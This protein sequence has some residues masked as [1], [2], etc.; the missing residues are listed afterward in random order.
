MGAYN[1]FL[2]LRRILFL[3]LSLLVLS[4]CSMEEH[5]DLLNNGY[6]KIDTQAYL[7]ERP[8]GSG[9]SYF[10]VNPLGKQQLLIYLKSEL[11]KGRQKVTNESKAERQHDELKAIERRNRSI[12]QLINALNGGA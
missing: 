4:S 5:Q 11:V 7:K 1:V 9:F 8:D 2:P 10:T 12:E 3:A 6:S